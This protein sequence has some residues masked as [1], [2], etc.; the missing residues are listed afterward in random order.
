MNP[1]KRAL[2]PFIEELNGYAADLEDYVARMEI[3]VARESLRTQNRRLS[4]GN[5]AQN[6]SLAERMLN[7]AEIIRNVIAQIDLG[8]DALE[9]VCQALPEMSLLEE[10]GMRVAEKSIRASVLD[11]IFGA[12]TESETLHCA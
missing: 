11:S 5:A 10:A 6:V 3:A 2:T 7:G 1:T 12:P 9:E 4:V 8:L